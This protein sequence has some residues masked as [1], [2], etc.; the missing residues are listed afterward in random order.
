MFS[1]EFYFL[2]IL[3][4]QCEDSFNANLEPI[5]V[6]KDLSPDDAYEFEINY[7]KTMT[8]KLK[9]QGLGFKVRA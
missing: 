3:I 8:G 5:V 4:D 6:P 2:R 9:L 7:K 1:F